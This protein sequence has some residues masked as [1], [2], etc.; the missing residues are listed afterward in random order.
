MRQATAQKIM[1]ALS[2]IAVLLMIFCGLRYA[3]RTRQAIPSINDGTADWTQI[4]R[5]EIYKG[6]Y[7]GRPAVALDDHDQISKLVTALQKTSGYRKLF[8]NQWLEGMHDIWITFDNGVV[9][10]MYRAE[11]YGYIGT[12]MKSISPGPFYR[13]PKE[14]RDMVLTLLETAESRVRLFQNRA[15]IIPCE[16]PVFAEMYSK[17]NWL[18]ADSQSARSILKELAPDLPEVT[19]GADLEICIPQSE[20]AQLTSIDLYD[21]NCSLVV[22]FEEK[23]AFDN[24]CEELE[25]GTYYVSA[26]VLRY[27]E[28]IKSADRYERFGYEYIFRLRKPS[29]N[30]RSQ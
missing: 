26:S 2:A 15:E 4:H 17:R 14:F 27:G 10:G 21:E 23:S 28:Y 25:P 8:E 13:F 12:E 5:I 6:S 16:N 30:E 1:I 24:Y 7:T 11:N 20:T 29:V 22:Q 3:V 9:T 18:A 19:L